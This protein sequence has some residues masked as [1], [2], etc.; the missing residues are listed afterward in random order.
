MSESLQ[1]ETESLQAQI[2]SL[3]RSLERE[4]KGRKEA[5][6]V[7]R[8]Q[9]FELIEAKKIAQNKANRLQQALSASKQI[10]WEWHA[11]SDE[12]LMYSNESEAQSR[13][14]NRITRTEFIESL[15]PSHRQVFEHQF[16]AHSN[17]R[18]KMFS[19]VVERMSKR[20]NQHRWVRLTG[21]CA[22]RDEDGRMTSMLGTF[23]DI[24]S[25]HQE[26]EAYEIVTR[27]F[28][29]AKK[30]SFILSLEDKK[31]QI[32]TTFANM[33]DIQGRHIEWDALCELLPVELIQTHQVKGSLVFCAD[34]LI[35]G[36]KV[37]CDITLTEMQTHH[38]VFSYTYI[39][40]TC[41]PITE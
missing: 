14:V 9:T 38:N 16:T 33:F 21:Q 11:K 34:L 32:N 7:L 1:A 10:V 40:G 17:G 12:I 24:T 35:Q 22:Q 30:P 27:A 3:K 37:R 13:I 2:A 5:E 39:C 41:L 25:Q 18:S 28:V 8:S 29:N 26:R 23:K 19:V 36:Q 31:V 6:E 20:T 4:R 15:R